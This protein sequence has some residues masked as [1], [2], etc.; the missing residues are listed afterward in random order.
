MFFNNLPFPFFPTFFHSSF[1]SPF[2]SSLCFYSF[3]TLHSLSSFCLSRLPASCIFLLLLLLLLFSLLSSCLASTHLFPLRRRPLSPSLSV[4]TYHTHFPL[5]HLITAASFL[6]SLLKSF[7][8]SLSLSLSLSLSR[9]SFFVTFFLFHIFFFYIL[10]LFV[11]KISMVFYFLMIFQAASSFILPLKVL[12]PCPPSF[13]L[14]FLSF[15]PFLFRLSR[16]FPFV[17]R[18]KIT[19]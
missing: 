2:L 1:P 11:T 5:P 9:I 16:S 3:F 10:V 12:S 14:S 19:M 13:I 8:F 6:F 7:F 17:I 15:L 4:L 18:N